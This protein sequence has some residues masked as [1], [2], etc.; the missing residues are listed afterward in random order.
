VAA[1]DDAV[2]GDQNDSVMFVI[3]SLPGRQAEQAGWRRAAEG[4]RI[5]RPQP[6]PPFCADQRVHLLFSAR[7][8]LCCEG[9]G[10]SVREHAHRHPLSPSAS[11]R[12]T[13]H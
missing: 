5:L 2:V 12:W 4:E 7:F 8:L 13:A 1:R 9:A 10:T 11:G 6:W 3:L